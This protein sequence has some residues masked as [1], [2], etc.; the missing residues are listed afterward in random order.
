MMTGFIGAAKW[1]VLAFVFLAGVLCT[2]L[3]VRARSALANR[4]R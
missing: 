3:V 1:P 2:L 4:R